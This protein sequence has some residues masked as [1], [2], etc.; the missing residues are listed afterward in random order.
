[1]APPAV[2]KKLAGDLLK[3]DAANGSIAAA[4]AKKN[5][6]LQVKVKTNKL[7]HSLIDSDDTF[8]SVLH[9]K[10]VPDHVVSNSSSLRSQVP[11]QWIH[12]VRN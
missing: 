2:G 1:M 4:Y 3:F 11:G 8:G 6:A 5:E 12:K 9:E 10:N 7:R